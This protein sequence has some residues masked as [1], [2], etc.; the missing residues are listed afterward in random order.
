[1]HY[2][3]YKR[4]RES[5]KYLP[6]NYFINVQRES[7]ISS[8]KLLFDVTGVFYVHIQFNNHM[9]NPLCHNIPIYTYPLQEQMKQN[10]RAVLVS[11]SEMRKAAGV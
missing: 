9:Q 10:C 8:P 7:E 2:L 3:S 11:Q 6:K 4:D 5:Q 1:M